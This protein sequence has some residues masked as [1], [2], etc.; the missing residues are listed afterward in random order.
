MRTRLETPQGIDRSGKGFGRAERRPPRRRPGRRFRLALL[1]LLTA[2]VILG[3]LFHD[4][5][6][7]GRRQTRPA[8]VRVVVP[9]DSI[10]VTDGDTMVIQWSGD[11]RERVRV[12]GIDTP[13][14]AHDNH[15]LSEDQPYGPEASA[16]AHEAFARAERIELLRADRTDGYGRTL[17][18][19]FLDGRNYSVEVLRARLAY[20]TVSHFGDNGLPEQARACLEAAHKA[21]EKGPLPFEKPYLFRRRMREK[22]AAKAAA[23]A[24]AKDGD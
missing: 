17:G 14:V 2:G 3:G 11:D 8:G 23:K 10:R 12:L 20:E 15:F 16:F 5:G 7:K 18:Y 6:A 9:P 24:D 4:A 1:L 21:L 13:E 19:F 22:A